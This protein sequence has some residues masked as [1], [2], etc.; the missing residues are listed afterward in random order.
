[1]KDG[2]DFPELEQALVKKPLEPREYRELSDVL[3]PGWMITHFGNIKD[4]MEAVAF[5]P[6]SFFSAQF[7]LIKF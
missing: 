7:V 6:I 1:M 2:D 3:G 5:V 4:C